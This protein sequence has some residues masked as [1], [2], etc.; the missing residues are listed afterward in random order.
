MRF[1]RRYPN[2]A[3]AVLKKKGKHGKTETDRAKKHYKK[4]PQLPPK[5]RKPFKYK[6]YTNDDVKDTLYEM[7]NN[8]C[9]YCETRLATQPMDVEHWRPKNAVFNEDTKKLMKPGYYWLGA[10][11]NN[12]FPACID[13]NRARNHKHY[14]TGEKTKLGKAN[15]FPVGDENRRWRKHTYQNQE[16]PL[17]L[18]PC[19]DKPEKYLE[20]IED[21]ERKVC[22]VRAKLDES[23]N[24][25]E[26]AKMSIEV[27]G[28]NR[29]G[30]IQNRQE[31]LLSIKMGL[32]WISEKTKKLLA[33]NNPIEK[34]RI[35]NDITRIMGDLELQTKPENE[36]A[37]YTLMVEQVIERFKSSI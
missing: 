9:A 35:E 21:E 18:N 5:K 22:I 23:G 15:R 11:W 13:C 31:K 6:V 28:L 19:Q 36:L 37:Q 26:K 4:W 16:K 7:F 8:K 1:I 27:Y 3:P 33:E 2:K 20:F 30:L 34:Q 29:L 25:K 12:L 24:P 17:L 10:D 14:L 32:N